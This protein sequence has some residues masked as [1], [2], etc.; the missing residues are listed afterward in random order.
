MASRVEVSSLDLAPPKAWRRLVPF[1]L[2][3]VQCYASR[4]TVRYRAH[5]DL[6]GL[7]QRRNHGR[8][9]RIQGDAGDARALPVCP[10]VD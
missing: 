3:S 9:T 4:A 5:A 1:W 10:I 8:L 7:P 2:R 6:G